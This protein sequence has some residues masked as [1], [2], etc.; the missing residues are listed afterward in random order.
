MGDGVGGQAKSRSILIAGAG[1]VG[2]TAAL[3]LARR[4]FAPRIIDDGTGP[5]PDSLVLPRLNWGRMTQPV[6]SERD[7]HIDE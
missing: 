4:G 7:L 6:N 3:E 2:L 1:P 5:T